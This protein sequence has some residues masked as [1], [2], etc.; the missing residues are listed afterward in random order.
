MISPKMN[1]GDRVLVE[2]RCV[3]DGEGRLS[4]MAEVIERRDA[5]PSKLHRG[6]AKQLRSAAECVE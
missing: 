1:P 2:Y 5:K 3:Q 4:I 6:R